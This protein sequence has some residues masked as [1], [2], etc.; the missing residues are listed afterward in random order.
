MESERAAFDESYRARQISKLTV[1]VVVLSRGKDSN[2]K[3]VKIQ[4]ELAGISKDSVRRTVKKSGE[5]IPIAQPK[6]VSST[7]IE[8][9]RT[10]RSG[11]P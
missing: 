8:M 9:V 3:I 7:V 1:P 11:R 2:D 10:I 6:A 4:N 5:Q